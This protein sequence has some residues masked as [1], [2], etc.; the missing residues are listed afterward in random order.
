MTAQDLAQQ[1]CAPQKG[2]HKRLTG[3]TLANH[4]RNVPGWIET[5]NHI[6][7]D[8]QFVGYAQVV[9]FVNQVATLA[10]AENHHPDIMFGFN[11]VRVVFTTHSVRGVSVNDLIC[12]ARIEAM[13]SL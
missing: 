2:A 9:E 1:H 7:K 3:D 12:A 11:R 8:F 5:D 6:S 4:L 10:M 13:R